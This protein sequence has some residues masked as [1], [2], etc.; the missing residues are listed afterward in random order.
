MNVVGNYKFIVIGSSGVGKTCLLKRLTKGTFD[1]DT[2]STVG[3]QFESLPLTIEDRK[4]KLQIWDTAGQERFHSTSKTYYRNAVGVALV[5][6]VTDRVSFDALPLWLSD[7]QSLCDPNAV[8]LLIGNKCDLTDDR[9]VTIIEAEG[10]ARGH[11]M[12]Y[13]ETS[14]QSGDNVRE[15]FVTI[16][17]AIVTRG[18]KTLHGPGNPR[19]VAPP[20]P[21]AGPPESSC[22]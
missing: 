19:P 20:P 18:L 4:I 16:A 11:Q 7:I 17:I 5:F 9:V 8:I 15:A 1:E 12:S 6:D 3:A 13:L 21:A 2:A 10:F 14:A 22:C